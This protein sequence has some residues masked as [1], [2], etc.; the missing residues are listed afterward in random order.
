MRSSEAGALVTERP[1]VQPQSAASVAAP[2]AIRVEGVSKAF[3]DKVVLDNVSLSIAAGSVYGL[4]GPN[5]A[6]KTTLI[7]ILTTLLEPT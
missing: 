4:L 2:P 5:G 1:G 3:G 6:G 7:R